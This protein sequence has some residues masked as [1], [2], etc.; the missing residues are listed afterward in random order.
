M[1]V[2]NR[3]R[4]HDRTEKRPRFSER[5]RGNAEYLPDDGEHVEPGRPAAGPGS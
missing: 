3:R 1:K 2:V 5:Y 4:L